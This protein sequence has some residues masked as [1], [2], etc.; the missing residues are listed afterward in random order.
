MRGRADDPFMVFTS[1]H[2]S[3]SH[4]HFIRPVQLQICTMIVFAGVAAS[5]TRIGR[6]RIFIVGEEVK[7]DCVSVSVLLRCLGRI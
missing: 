5:C 7:N 2:I 4:S 6:E 3:I 1:V